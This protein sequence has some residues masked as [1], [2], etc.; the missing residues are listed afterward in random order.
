MLRILGAIVVAGLTAGG[1]QASSFVSVAAPTKTISASF[2]VV[3]APSSFAQID[4]IETSAMPMTGSAS[5]V[6][7]AYPLPDGKPAR[8]VKISAS[9]VAYE[10]QMPAIAYEMV[11]SVGSSPSALRPTRL[12][13][14]MVMRGGIMGDGSAAPVAVVASQAP[15]SAPTKKSRVGGKS[16]RAPTEEAPKP[17]VIAPPPPNLPKLEGAR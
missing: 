2:V 10:S 16:G 3:G 4:E 14:P 1:A 17:I 13:T 11:A 5:L 6:P 7:L 8:A 9:I 15:A 12:W